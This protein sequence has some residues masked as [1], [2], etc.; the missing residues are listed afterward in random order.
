[1]TPEAWARGLGELLLA[2]LPGWPADPQESQ[3]R[4]TIY[5]RHLDDLTDAQWA[6]AVAASIERERWFP[7]VA[8]LR[9]YG[10]AYR[11][12]MLALPPAGPRDPGDVAAAQEGIKRG[13]ALL[14][15][16]VARVDMEQAGGRE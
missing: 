4:A 2:G 5:R 6:H 15:A 7:G 13:L 16:A 9:E 8:V 10:E 14:R 11:P 12:P 1:V 3:A